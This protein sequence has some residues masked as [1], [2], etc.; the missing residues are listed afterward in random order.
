MNTIN[1]KLYYFFLQPSSSG[2]SAELLATSTIP[3]NVGFANVA[4]F[5]FLPTMLQDFPITE[6][7]ID[8]MDSTL[9]TNFQLVF[10]KMTKKD[11]TTKV[12]ALQEF[13]ELVLKTDASTIKSILPFWPRLYNNL[14][15]DVEHRV[16][17]AAQQAQSALMSQ[18]GK[19]IAPYLKQLA[20]A[21]I[22]SQYDT[23]A[24]AASI[25]MQSFKKSFPAHKL[26]DVF[27]F[28]QNEILDYVTKNL[29][30]YTATT[31]SNPQ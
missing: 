14:S 2:R 4:Q 17:E 7:T 31:L 9:D 11:S 10:R 6:S 5:G 28:C 8:D 13:S 16:R 3:T 27:N 26:Q 15:T 21:W 12:K 25:A 29:T 20:P 22:A 19:N 1:E 18:A 24:P 30:V 23:Y